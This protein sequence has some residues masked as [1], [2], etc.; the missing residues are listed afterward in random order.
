VRV[1][2]GVEPASIGPA[3]QKIVAALDPRL[4]RVGVRS[5]TAAA[6]TGLLPQRVAALVTASLGSLGLLLAAIGLYGVTTYGVGQR[7]R[8]IGVR[9]ALGATE[10]GVVRMVVG[11]AWKLATIGMVSGLLVAML[12]SRVLSRFLFGVSPLDP[13]TLLSVPVLLLGVALLAS[14]L[15][16]RQAA[17]IDVVRALRD[18]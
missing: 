5:L 8:E 12:L 9:M 14:W 16:A 1:R 15:P 4:P 17:R 2:A 6:A 11:E 13:L 10:S 7:V 3:V 18:G